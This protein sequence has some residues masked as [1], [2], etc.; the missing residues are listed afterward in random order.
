MYRSV[1]EPISQ[2]VILTDAIINS[3]NRFPLTVM[4]PVSTYRLLPIGRAGV[5]DPELR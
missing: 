1:S 2:R 4:L 3:Q 5:A